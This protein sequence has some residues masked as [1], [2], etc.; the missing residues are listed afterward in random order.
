MGSGKRSRTGERSQSRALGGLCQVGEG[1]EKRC[2]G[3]PGCIDWGRTRQEMGGDGQ[4][5]R[6]RNPREDTQF[7]QPTRTFTVQGE[8]VTSQKCAAEGADRNGHHIQAHGRAWVCG[9]V[10]GCGNRHPRVPLSPCASQAAGELQQ[11]RGPSANTPIL[12][13]MNGGRVLGR[14]EE[15]GGLQG[16][17]GEGVSPLSQTAKKVP[18]AHPHPQQQVQQRAAEEEGGHQRERTKGDICG[19]R[20]EMPPQ[21]FFFSAFSA[22]RMADSSCQRM[23]KQCATDGATEGYE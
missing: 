9:C 16:G 10:E 15:E 21:R 2:A 4:P 6:G 5:W 11:G 23:C 3:V 22:L 17:E 8:G 18:L 7:Y 1:L 12:P 20:R 14:G 13:E 19:Q